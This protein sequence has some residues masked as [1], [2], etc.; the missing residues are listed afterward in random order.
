[1]TNQIPMT[2]DQ[3]RTRGAGGFFGHWDLVIDWS[4]GLGH[5]NFGAGA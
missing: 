4:L 2:N 1:M 3:R 5:W